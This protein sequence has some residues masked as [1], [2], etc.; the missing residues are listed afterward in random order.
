VSV[1][2]HCFAS[3]SFAAVCEALGKEIRDKTGNRILGQNRG[4]AFV[5]SRRW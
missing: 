4:S 2:E 1:L 3:K 5:F